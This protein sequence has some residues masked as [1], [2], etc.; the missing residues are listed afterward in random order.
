M[1]CTWLVG[2]QITLSVWQKRLGVLIYSSTLCG[3]LPS[4][5]LMWSPRGHVVRWW[6]CH[7]VFDL[8]S[9]LLLQRRRRRSTPGANSA[10]APL[11]S[12]VMPGQWREEGV[13]C[14]SAPAAKTQ[15]NS[16]ARSL[17][18]A[19]SDVRLSRR[20]RRCLCCHSIC[21]PSA[22]CNR[23]ALLAVQTFQLRSRLI[24]VAPHPTP[25]AANGSD[26]CKVCTCETTASVCDRFDI[27]CRVFGKGSVTRLLRFACNYPAFSRLLSFQI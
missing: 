3:L 26:I 22:T 16:Q 1:S 13:S 2:I 10:F 4:S 18:L 24:S 9:C 11:F 8:S 15:S 12:E 23:P 7:E 25:L 20:C 6:T 14:G 19:H 17:Q 5:L 27:I 21:L